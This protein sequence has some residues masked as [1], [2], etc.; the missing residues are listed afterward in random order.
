MTADGAMRTGE[1]RWRWPETNGRFN[2][3][4]SGRAIRVLA[5]VP[6]LGW[7]ADLFT[8][9]IV[10]D[11]ASDGGLALIHRPRVSGHEAPGGRV[12]RPVTDEHDTET[13]IRPCRSAHA[14]MLVGVAS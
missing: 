3:P 4:P 11:D 12:A 6:V 1:S 2:H 7:P 9:T 10:N 5:P 8:T 14:S 13:I